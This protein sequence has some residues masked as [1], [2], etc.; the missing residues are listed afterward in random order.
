VPQPWL[1]VPSG[2]VAPRVF[3]CSPLVDQSHNDGDVVHLR[4][5]NGQVCERLQPDARGV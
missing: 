1:G 5:R 2:A 4:E 3:V